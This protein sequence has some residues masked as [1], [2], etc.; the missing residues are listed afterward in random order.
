[1]VRFKGGGWGRNIG[2]K[3]G[4]GFEGGRGGKLVRVEGWVWI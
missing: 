2:W 1:M 4:F 3:G